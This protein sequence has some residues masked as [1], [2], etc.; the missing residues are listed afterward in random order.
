[1][2]EESTGHTSERIKMMYRWSMEEL[3]KFEDTLELPE[4]EEIEIGF[5]VSSLCNLACRSCQPSDSSL[6]RQVTG[7]P[8]LSPM[9]EVDLLKNERYW[10]TIT[11]QIQTYQQTHGNITIHP[12][13]GE[14]FVT[15]GF[16]KIVDWLCETEISRSSRLRVTTNFTVPI[17][18]WLDRFLKFRQVQLILSIDSVGVNYTQVR[19]PAQ[20]SKIERNIETWASYV[21]AN[22]T[23]LNHTVIETVFTINNIFYINTVLDWWL[24]L[25]ERHPY[26]HFDIDNL[27]CF[28]PECLRVENIPDPYR[29]DLIKK[30][31]MAKH[32]KLFD[33]KKHQVLKNFV[34]NM[35]NSLKEFSGSKT[36][37]WR[38]YLRY[39]AEYDRKTNS[40]S[41]V[42]NQLLF[43]MLDSEDIEYYQRHFAAPH[44]DKIFW[45]E[46]KSYKKSL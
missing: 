40:N 23:E 39:T 5:K 8:P 41:F 25:S 30:L 3:A 13:G 2:S 26:F 7:H 35:L 14:T 29:T 6:F 27:H 22:P 33:T 45:P 38:D 17:D 32:H 12:I 18:N 21:K 24:G 44:S 34:A 31:E 10:D 9:H 11:S 4:Q 1:M 19:W 42:G 28:R 20:W 37:Q 43:E 15:D 46:F 36:E 16:A